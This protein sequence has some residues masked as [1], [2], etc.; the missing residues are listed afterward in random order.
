MFLCSTVA[1]RFGLSDDELAAHLAELVEW[2]DGDYGI[3]RFELTGS[4]EDNGPK[5][6]RSTR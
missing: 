1:L 3:E 2:Y 4:V 5:R 6:R